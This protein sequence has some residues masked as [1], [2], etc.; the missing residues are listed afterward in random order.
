MTN[1]D[2]RYK[3]DRS[4]RHWSTQPVERDYWLMTR[5]G[6]DKERLTYFNEPSVPELLGG[7]TIVAACEFS[8]D[9]HD[10]AG[11]LGIDHGA[12][13]KRQMTLKVVLI[14]LKEAL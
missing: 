13:K 3:L 14:R 12:G 5:D 10:L 11:T 7:R 8:P 9:G 4:N 1:K 2:S 6:K